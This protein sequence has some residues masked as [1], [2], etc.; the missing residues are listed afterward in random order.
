MRACCE[1][2]FGSRDLKGRT[3]AVVG[4]GRVGSRLARRLARAGAK[5]IARRHRRGQ[6][7]AREVDRREMGRRPSTALLAEVDVLAPCALGGAIDQVVSGRLR[8]QVVCG[9]ANNQLEHDGL[10][11]DLAAHGILFAPDFIASAGGLINI[12]VEL[13]GYDPARAR[14]RVA[15]IE[16]T[17][18]E[19]L[20][21]AEADGGDAAGG[22]LR[23]RP[24]AARR[25]YREHMSVSP[26]G[27]A[28]AAN[29]AEI[30]GGTPMVSLTRVAPDCGA[31]L[32]GEARGLQPRG[33]REGPDRRLDDRRRRGRGPD[34][35]RPDDGGRGHLR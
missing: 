3:V 13:E 20:D 24:H 27:R 26:I 5:L 2:R 4:A 14:R 1:R 8:C 17:M 32:V 9:S 6:A 34:R 25:R 12:S 15:G 30:V 19:V 11:E 35:A 28:I 7:R 18:G 33:Q 22:R 31:E 21:R 16:E 10:A 23:A 29:L